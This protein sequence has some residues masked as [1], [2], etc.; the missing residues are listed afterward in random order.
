MAPDKMVYPKDNFL[1]SARKHILWFSLEAPRRGASNEYLQHMFPC[2]NKK[3]SNNFRMKNRPYLVLWSV[4]MYILQSGQGSW[5][6]SKWFIE[7]TE[8]ASVGDKTD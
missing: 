1:T 5:F 4:Y 7:R 2:R 6:S 8:L 3:N